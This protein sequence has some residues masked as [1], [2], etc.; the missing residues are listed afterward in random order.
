MV[1]VYAVLET[2]IFCYWYLKINNSALKYY[3]LMKFG[4]SFTDAPCV[5]RGCKNGPAPFPGRMSYKATKPQQQTCL[6]YLSMFLL[7]CCVLGPL[8]MYC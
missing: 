5:L 3:F 6:S 7:C 4:S 8:F 1:I 2:E